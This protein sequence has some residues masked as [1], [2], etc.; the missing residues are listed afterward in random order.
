MSSPPAGN[1]V[2][3]TMTIVSEFRACGI[4]T[5]GSARKR[6]DRLTDRSETTPMDMFYYRKPRFSS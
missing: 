3:A 5:E 2:N 4:L 1:A 6:H